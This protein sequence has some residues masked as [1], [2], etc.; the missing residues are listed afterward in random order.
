[1]RR[2]LALMLQHCL[3]VLTQADLEPSCFRIKL[4]GSQASSIDT[5]TIA[6]AAVFEYACAIA[7]CK[8]VGGRWADVADAAD[9]LH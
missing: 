6:D 2:T 5:D 1:M 3:R 7:Y 9:V 8:L 4:R